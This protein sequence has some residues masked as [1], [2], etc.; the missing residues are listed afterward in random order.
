MEVTKYQIKTVEKKI[1]TNISSVFI[2]Y[3]VVV[4]SLNFKP[5]KKCFVQNIIEI[6]QN[7]GISN[8][9]N[10]LST[11]TCWESTHSFG[12]QSCLVVL[13]RIFKKQ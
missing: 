12:Y 10:F 11:V 5:F 3:Y 2:M 6:L 7:C 1:C 9:H 4:K 8:S 13:C